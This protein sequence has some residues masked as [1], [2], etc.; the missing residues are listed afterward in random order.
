MVEM[1]ATGEM[2]F[3]LFA[4]EAHAVDLVGSFTEWERGA[5]PMHE[6]GGGW[7]TFR[8]EIKPGDHEF[9][10]RIDGHRRQ[11]DYAAH[12]VRLD[13]F[14]QWVSGLVVPSIGVIDRAQ[15][16]APVT[17]QGGSAQRLAA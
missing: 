15:V 13:R 2:E 12:G 5:Q 14:G 6:A 1:T 10:Y 16:T 9:C 3:R 8:A 11:A 7:W 17:T 4:P